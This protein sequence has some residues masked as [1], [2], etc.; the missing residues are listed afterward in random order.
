MDRL[1]IARRIVSA[2][3]NLKSVGHGIS[4]A[5]PIPTDEEENLKQ[6]AYAL[7]VMGPDLLGVC[8]VDL[9]RF[10]DMGPS[11]EYYPNHGYYTDGGHSV[12]LNSQLVRDTYTYQDA[13]SKLMSKFQ[14]TLWHVLGHAFDDRMGMLSSQEEWQSLSGWTERPE[15][16]SGWESIEI[17]EPGTK[18][19]RYGWWHAP[20]SKFTRFYARSNP[21]D[22]FAD[23]FAYYVGGMHGFLP[24]NK[25]QFMARHIALATRS[26]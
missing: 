4:A 1:K 20:E 3:E 14:Q 8:G 2:I 18:A 19:V 10:E 5:C 11:R 25:I 23:S 16:G 26:I 15:K 6:L 13:D 17:A 7:D 12:T 21:W 22:D 9:V 24:E